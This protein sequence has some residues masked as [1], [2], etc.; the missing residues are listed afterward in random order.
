VISEYARWV[1]GGLDEQLAL[2]AAN[3]KVPFNPEKLPSHDA[4]R[5]FMQAELVSKQFNF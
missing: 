5:Q 2:L 1:A 3:A 4:L